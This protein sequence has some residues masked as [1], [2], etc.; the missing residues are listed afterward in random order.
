MPVRHAR[1]KMRGR[2]PFGRRGAVGKERFDWIPQW[3]GKQRCS[4]YPLT[5]LSPAR[6]SGFGGFCYLLLAN[7]ALNFDY[8]VPGTDRARTE[9]PSR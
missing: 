3:I 5:L 9:R 2:P 8:D 4:P 6:N 7:F 1:Y